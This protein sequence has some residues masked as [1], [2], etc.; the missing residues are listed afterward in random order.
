MWSLSTSD[1]ASVGSGGGVRLNI[2]GRSPPGDVASTEEAPPPR[3][4]GLL[5]TLVWRGGAEPRN[6][7]VEA[8]PGPG[9]C[10]EEA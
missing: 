4:C 6:V 2:R 9:L 1:G 7:G 10:V 5:G 8:D 3:A